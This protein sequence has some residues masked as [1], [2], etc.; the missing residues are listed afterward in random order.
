[1]KFNIN[2]KLLRRLRLSHSHKLFYLAYV[3]KSGSSSFFTHKRVGILLF[4]VAK[5]YIFYRFAKLPQ[6]I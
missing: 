1:M 2:M 5:I 3:V 6:L 4:F